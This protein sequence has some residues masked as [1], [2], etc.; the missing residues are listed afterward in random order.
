MQ[1]AAV[2]YLHMVA[3][4]HILPQGAMLSDAGALLNVA[5]IPDLGALTDLYIVIHEA[6]WMYKIF[7]LHHSASKTASMTCC[8]SAASIYGC[9][10]S[11]RVRAQ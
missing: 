8:C 5:E 6:G 11:D 3:D 2:A 9:M 1:L 10:G 4:I 7:L